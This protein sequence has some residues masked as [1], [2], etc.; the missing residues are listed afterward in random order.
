LMR[1]D[2]DRIA[3]IERFTVGFSIVIMLT[4]RDRSVCATYLIREQFEGGDNGSCLA[5]IGR[6]FREL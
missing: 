1:V 3:A 4:D 5:D 2:E 6:L